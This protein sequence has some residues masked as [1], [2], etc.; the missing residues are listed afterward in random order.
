LNLGPTA[1]PASSKVAVATKRA[2]WDLRAI[3][4]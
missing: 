1:Q 2:E 4:M 3:I